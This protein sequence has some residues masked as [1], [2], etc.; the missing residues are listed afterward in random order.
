MRMNTAH[1]RPGPARVAARRRGVNLTIPEDVMAEAKALNLNASKA[2]EAGI[3]EAIRAAREA[4]WLEA[5]RPAIEAHNA[6]IAREGPH[7]VADW[8][9]PFWKKSD[10]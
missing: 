5:A 1:K 4:E 6:R 8:A 7:V 9:K 10:D 2:A 3:R